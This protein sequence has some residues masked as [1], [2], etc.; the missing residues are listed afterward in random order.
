MEKLQGIV[1]KHSSKLK[2]LFVLGAIIAGLNTLSR[3]DYNFVIYLYMLYVWAFL[4]KNQNQD[5]AFCFF[6]LIFSLLID[7]FWCIYWQGKWEGIISLVHWL[8]LVLSWLG[9]FLKLVIILIV[10]ILDLSSI[11]GSL[12]EKMNP[13]IYRPQIDEQL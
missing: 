10:A 12:S 5:K 11:K 6:I 13:E 9:I 4:P 8:T 2:Y 7:I 1:S 3:A